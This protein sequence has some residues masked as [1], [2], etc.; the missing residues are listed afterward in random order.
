MSPHQNQ[1]LRL[2]EISGLQTVR[3]NLTSHVTLEV[4]DMVLIHE[5]LRAVHA[6]PEFYYRLSG[7]GE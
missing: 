7:I 1:F 2:H 6:A 3:F 4:K 5:P